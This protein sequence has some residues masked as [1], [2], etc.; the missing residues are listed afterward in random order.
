MTPAFLCV[1][2]AS[3][4]VQAAALP[5]CQPSDY[6]ELEQ[7][8]ANA[9]SRI[10]V[11]AACHSKD[12]GGFAP[13]GSETYLDVSRLRQWHLDPGRMRLTVGAGVMYLDVASALA[14]ANLALPAYGNYGGQTIVGAMSTSTHGAGRPSLA[15]FVTRMHVIDGRGR[16]RNI[17]R[18]DHDFPAWANSL[19]ALGVVAEADFELTP[20]WHVL[21]TTVVNLEK[22]SVIRMLQAHP[23]SYA[24]HA[25][26]P[27]NGR[28]RSTDPPCH[29][30]FFA[31]RRVETALRVN[32]T[33]PKESY[34][35]GSTHMGGVDQPRTY[36]FNDLVHWERRKKQR[37]CYERVSK[38]GAWLGPVGNLHSELELMF[39]PDQ[40]LAAIDVLEPIRYGSSSTR[41]VVEFRY[42]LRDTKDVLL[43]PYRDGDRIAMSIP[44]VNRANGDRVVKVLTRAGID[45]RFH[46]GKGAPR[47]L[48]E[49][50]T[51]DDGAARAFE[52]AKRANDPTSRFGSAYTDLL[53]FCKTLASGGSGAAQQSISAIEPTTSIMVPTT[54]LPIGASTSTHF[55]MPML[56]FGPQSQKPDFVVRALQMGFRHVDSSYHYGEGTSLRNIGAGIAQFGRRENIFITTKVNGCGCAGGG[57]RYHAIRSETCFEDTLRAVQESLKELR[58]TFID[59]L[60]LHHPP[61]CRQGGLAAGHAVN[62]SHPRT[63]LLVQTQWRALEQSARRGFAN[64]IGVSNYCPQCMDC[65]MRSAN[66]APAVA[67]L[68]VNVGASTSIDTLMSWSERHHVHIMAYSPINGLGLS[69]AQ[70]AEVARI[71][72]QHGNMSFVQ[73][74]LRWL[75]QHGVTPIVS[76]RNVGHLQQ[77]LDSFRWRLSDPAMKR[78]DEMRGKTATRGPSQDCTWA[79][80]PTGRR[81][82]KQCGALLRG[83]ASLR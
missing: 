60:L 46:R 75:T 15:N 31:W 7:C 36:A 62:C 64:Q 56:A 83:T 1:G 45:V 43:S 37:P 29:S 74:V 53:P 18:S 4:R 52:R 34:M 8:S 44:T 69:G 66:K 32:A 13:T 48:V 35:R 39:R 42:V 23:L 14:A 20:N 25:P 80:V 17:K 61:T 78:L 40:L 22:T 6:A 63:C 57:R 41:I 9:S 77:N 10:I 30:C 26:A 16:R 79:D 76:S 50:S 58:S 54:A 33:Y 70:R 12:T 38:Q 28:R 19:G 2:Y 81:L 11:A 67:Q 24:F 47:E 65:L 71:G 49:A 27:A 5:R 68:M 72:A 21:E 3:V 59:L 55:E 82:L 51:W 73:V